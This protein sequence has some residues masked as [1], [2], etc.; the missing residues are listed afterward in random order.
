MRNKVISVVKSVLS[1]LLGLFVICDA[2]AIGLPAGYTELEYIKS[3]GSQYITMP[4][5]P[6]ASNIDVVV[7]VQ[8]TTGEN[9]QIFFAPGSGIQYLYTVS[10]GWR[11][12]SPGT[13]LGSLFDRH[14]ITIKTTPSSVEYYTDGEKI[15]AVPANAYNSGQW[16]GKMFNIGA[17][18]RE[19]GTGD[20]FW[21]GKI[22]SFK[23]TCDG[24]VCIDLVPA[25]HGDDIGMYD[26]AS[27]TFIRG[28]GTFTGGPMACPNGGKLQ[29]YTTVAAADVPA[30]VQNGT[31]T[32]ANPIEPVFYQ[33]GNMVLRKVGDIA[34]SYD[35]TTGKITRRVG[36]KVLDGTENWIVQ[37]GTYPY[38]RW[39]TDS[40]SC[41]D[42]ASS[43]SL[44]SHFLEKGISINN[45]EQGFSVW[46]WIQNNVGVVSIRMD[47]TYVASAGTLDNFKQWLAAQYNAGTPV[48][49]WYPLATP[50][51]ED[52]AAEQCSP[53]KIATTK[54]NNA[55]FSGV[56]TALSNAVDTIKTVVANTINQ[57]T[58]VANLQS[59]K[60]QRPNPTAT[61][62]TCPNYRQC[63]LVEDQAGNPHWFEIMDP[64]YNL[65][66]AVIPNNVSSND[67]GVT[68]GYTQLDYVEFNN[69]QSGI[70]TDLVGFDS[71]NWEI[72]V[73]WM[74]LA[75]PTANWSAIF[76]VYQSE[77][78]C[79]YRVIHSQTSPTSYYLTANAA[80]GSGGVGP[81]LALNQIHTVTVRTNHE[82]TYDGTS[83]STTSSCQTLSSSRPLTMYSSGYRRYYS[84]VATKDNVVQMNLVPARRNSDG[85]VGFYDTVTGK[86]YSS[87]NDYN[88][89][90][91]NVVPNTDI[92]FSASPQH[93]SVNFAAN[94]PLDVRYTVYGSAKC[95]A[96]SGTANTAATSNQMSNANWTATGNNCW[97]NIERVDEMETGNTGLST[98]NI[99]VWL[100]VPSGQTCAGNCASNCANAVASGAAANK[101][102]RQAITG[103]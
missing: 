34:D 26:L 18:T 8:H 55:A 67:A 97:C 47:D 88:L 12:W 101:P 68:D 95:N 32:P 51:E 99:W 77:Q 89:I 102:F 28:T 74:T 2:H 38:F 94:A 62:G 44:S 100:A 37:N 10:S 66:S 6:N 61:N 78:H 7:D 48:T 60:Q 64:F 98:G 87:T 1:A 42:Q 90:A 93:W 57:A 45:T 29:T 14:V 86:F 30:G 20:Y 17:R 82:V 16:S 33:Q 9:E 22:Y 11:Y 96:T 40:I 71:G 75:A 59:G 50:V 15:T 56:V 81:S 4:A 85:W 69:T 23:A 65:F 5:F 27:D 31:P 53:I 91:G 19:N 43:I 83:G 36:V 79:T 13:N 72:T 92:P 3:N 80:A 46:H 70:I 39:N 54:Y 24:Q 84:L 49:V 76:N 35:A 25:K 58:A 52:W 73:Q 21:K 41:A 63:L 103:I